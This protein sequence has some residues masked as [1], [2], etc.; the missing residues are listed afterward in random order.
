M[1]RRPRSCSSPGWSSPSCRR[2]LR[3]VT[4]RSRRRDPARRRPAPDGVARRRR[5][6]HRPGRHRVDDVRRRHRAAGRR[7][8]SSGGGAT[9]SRSSPAS[10]CS[11][12]SALL[13]HRRV[14]AGRGPYDV[15]TIGRWHG[16]SLPS[17]HGGGRVG[18][19]WSGSSTRSSCPGRPRSIAKA[20]GAVVVGD[21]AC[22][23][24]LYLGV[25]HP[26]DALIG[27][28]LGV[29]IPLIAFRFFTPNEVVPGDATT[30]ARRPTS[31]S[32]AAAAR[33][34]ATPFEDQLGVDGR[35]HQAGRPGRLGRLDT[36]AAAPRRRPRHLRVRE[37]L[38][39]EP[40]PRPT[41][42]TSSAARSCT[43]ASRTSAP[44][45]SVRR[46]VQYEDYAL[47]LLRDAA[48]RRR[49]RS[50]SSS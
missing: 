34:S 4:D 42:G 45:Q 5:P 36:A 12:C 1:A 21:R 8:S 30:A 9:C 18:S 3:R 40:R 2:P 19:P 24:R 27:V 11:R 38:R 7:W 46:L 50:A 6:G 10:S 25:D 13:L 43:D 26:F 35:R 28:A 39:D 20:V 15:T 37:A 16:Y 44:F 41:A 22:V 47:R 31:T 32:A 17:A 14:L 23:G 49:S 48:S 29:A 33:R